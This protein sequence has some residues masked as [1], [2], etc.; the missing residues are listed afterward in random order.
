[1][2][3]D[4]RRGALFA[5]LAGAAF[6]AM[7]AMV[8]LASAEL[9]NAMVVFL[10]TGFGL[11]FLLPWL[12][13]LEPRALVTRRPLAHLL[14]AALGLVAMYCFFF[15]IRHLDLANAVLLNYSQPLFI[16]FI[17]WV[18]VAEKPPARI[19]PAVAIGFAGVALIIKPDAG[20]ITPAALVGLASGLFAAAAMTAIRR[21][22]DSEPTT[23]IVFYFT[24]F[25]ALISLVPALWAW[26]TPS[27]FALLAMLA[28]G[29]FATAGQLLLTRAY[30]LAP[31]AHVGSLIYAAVVF[32][33]GLGWLLWGDVP[34]AYA[35]V[36]AALVIM[37]A[38]VVLFVRR[39]RT[40]AR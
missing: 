21:M 33:A 26:Q 12:L 20:L 10:R 31:A 5:L 9:P 40:N 15:A 38:C 32:A 24:A 8:K 39:K 13:H 11:V 22:A 6:A 4:L 17:A 37:A 36:G 25:G 18:W 34:D 23:R 16:P 28:A 14:R 19:W 30:T 35:A 29:G 7:G 27:A 2:T 1:M 3:T